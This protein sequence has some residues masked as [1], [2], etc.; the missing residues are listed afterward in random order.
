MTR[1]LLL[2]YVGLALLVLLVLEVPLG[3]AYGRNERADLTG[4]VERDAVAIASLSEDVLQ[5]SGSLA[6][7]A[8]LATRYQRDTGGRV[9]LVDRQGVSVVDSGAAV[10]RDFASRPEIAA[11][12]SGRVAT[13]VRHSH[14]LGTN[15]LYVAEPVASGG[16][17]HGAVRITYPTSAV[18]ARV[19]R[20]WLMLAAIAAL[21]LALAALVGLVLARSVTRPLQALEQAAGEAGGG[22]LSVRAPETGPPEVR[23]LA[24]SFNEMVTRLQELVGAQEN[25]VADASHQLR[26]PLTAL[27][28]RLENGDAEGALPEVERLSRLVDGLLALARA[29]AAPAETVELAPAVA[30]RLDAFTPLAEARSV[31]LEAC[32]AGRAI[33]GPDR[34]GQALDNL[35]A[36]ALAVAPAG[37][38]VTVSGGPAA[39][40]VE[41]G[42]PGMSDEERERAFD[43]FWSKGSGSGLGLPI[44]KRL[45]E[46]DGGSLELHDAPGGGLDVVLRLRPA[47]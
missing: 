46:L 2:T 45:V 31:R 5:G 43:R 15:L 12:L 10:P 24:A 18:D 4:K 6:P 1:R 30:D 3:I 20:Y 34:L 8:A 25:F 33:V 32:V 11:A 13:G 26:T 41:D 40:H 28:L 27:R 9:V 23:S 7:L 37:S 19:T 17:V 22:D 29:E 16:L 38:A 14:T 47:P 44:V 36:N 35:L 42:G 39:L 21:V